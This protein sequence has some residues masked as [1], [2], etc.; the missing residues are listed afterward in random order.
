VHKYR[1]LVLLIVFLSGFIL[2]AQTES[3]K[4]YVKFKHNFQH[5][6]N[7]PIDD[8]K[9]ILGDF[10][11][12]PFISHKLL[13][14]AKKK[15][16]S[17]MQSFSASI[18]SNLERINIIEYSKPIDPLTV[19]KKISS[20]DGIE[21]AEPVP[22]HTFNFIPND[23]RIR[24]QFYLDK[25]QCFEA[26]DYLDDPD[27]VIVAIIDTGIDYTH[28]DLADNIFVNHGETGLDEFGN[29]KRDNGIDDDGNGLID[30]WRGW[31]FVSSQSATG[32][33]DP[34]PGHLH[35]THVGGTIGAVVNNGIGIAGICPVVRLMPV[36]VGGD[37]PLSVS[38]SNGYEGILYAAAMGA[39]V[40]NC[41]WGS[42]SRSVAE[43]EVIDAAV[44]LGCVVVAGAGNEGRDSEQFPASFD[45]VMSVAALE[46]DDKRSYFS[47][48]HTSVDVSAP[49]YEIYST[50]PGNW[51]D[52]LNGTSMASPI[53]AGVAALVIQK[54]ADFNPLQV[55]E[56]VKASCDDIYSVNIGYEGLLGKGRVNAY[57]AMTIE[58]P[59]SVIMTEHK[60]N[61]ENNDH[62][63]DAN[64]ILTID[65]KFLNVLSPVK[66]IRIKIKEVTLG[67][68]ELL[69]DEIEIGDMQTLEESIIPQ[70]FS[71]KIPQDIL[72]DFKCTIELKIYDDEGY[73]SKEYISMI[74]FPS[75]RTMNGNNITVTFNNRGN[76]A[77][78]DYPM[79]LQGDGFIYKDSPN[80]LFEGAFMVATAP[81]RVSNVARGSAQS[82]QNRSF[83]SDGVFSIF[84]PGDIADQEGS[85]SFRDQVSLDRDVGVTVKE[86][87]YQF[88]SSED[89]DYVIC[90]YD[91]VNVSPFDYDSLF[92]GLYFD[93]D[94]GPSG[95][96]NQAYF[97]SEL[98]YGFTKN[99]VEPELPVTA[100][101][102]LSF[103]KLN[104]FAIDNDGTS[105][106]NPGVWDGFTYAEKWRMLS[107]GIQRAESNITD[108]SQVIG[109]GPIKMNSGDSVRVSFAIFAADNDEDLARISKRAYQTAAQYGISNGNVNNVP[110]KVICSEVYPNPITQGELGFYLQ[111]PEE[112]TINIEI[113]DVS[114]RRVD[115]VSSENILIPGFYDFSVSVENIS[116]G[117]YFLKIST[118][119]ETFSKS[120]VI[121]R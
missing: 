45:G 52:F 82:A 109:A 7:A 49:G 36:K 65:L 72:H 93:W 120:F 91:I 21:Y 30:D 55:I 25:I 1:Y 14:S 74:L 90:V 86:H 18:F 115:H 20:L 12:R 46:K 44:A 95:M 81:D 78:N 117:T 70:A 79:N 42:Y 66:N 84:A 57:N 54:F 92:A 75:Y 35:G 9:T 118:K 39:D 105:E 22:I 56:Y 41:S 77:F 101:Q 63:Y 3:N 99:V 80:L 76:I 33:N 13:S 10:S 121:M 113:Y 71:F 37:N 85:V 53:A 83:F 26:W 94:I 108:A 106:E 104:Y 32:D 87:I 28:E 97:D 64:E 17:T 110:Q 114:G 19:S 27:T 5:S 98:R 100:V 69:K 119:N 11:I 68:I 23:P 31:D 2:S 29:D 116:Q 48:Y 38:V 24:D 73:E 51:Y 40:I 60:I 50:V 88:N 47:N 16:V 102:L 4:L 103:Q 89:Q 15:N 43:Q 8:F 111:I 59:R 96:N 61:D 62:A 112:T 58:N 6:E 67:G 107:G 34:M